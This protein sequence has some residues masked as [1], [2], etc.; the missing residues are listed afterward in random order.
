[1]DY[2][3]ILGLPHTAN[4]EDIASSFHRL[5]LFYHPLRNDLSKTAHFVQKFNDVCEAYEILSNPKAKQIYDA[6]GPAAIVNGISQGPEAFEGYN[7]SG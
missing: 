1:M 5:S 6:H 7:K 3:G 2:Y 4:R